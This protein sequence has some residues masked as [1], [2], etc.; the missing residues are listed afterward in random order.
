M[1]ELSSLTYLDIISNFSN[2]TPSHLTIPNMQKSSR[3]EEPTSKLY[4]EKHGWK[5]S[6]EKFVF[7]VCF[8]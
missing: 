4:I 2:S 6:E 7:P 8:L 1:N 3:C 5:S